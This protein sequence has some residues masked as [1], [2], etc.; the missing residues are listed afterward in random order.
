MQYRGSRTTELNVEKKRSKPRPRS[1]VELIIIIVIFIIIIIIIVII[2]ITND[3]YQGDKL[4]ADVRG[5]DGGSEEPRRKTS[6]I[7]QLGSML[8]NIL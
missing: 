2:I 4:E 3:D 6:F 8:K 7:E 5:E 1:Q